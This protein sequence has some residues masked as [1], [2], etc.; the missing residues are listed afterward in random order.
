MSI[1]DLRLR[2]N[3]SYWRDTPLVFTT[4]KSLHERF[5]P[6]NTTRCVFIISSTS[7]A[8]E[9]L[10]VS[11]QICTNVNKRFTPYRLSNFEVMANSRIENRRRLNH[12]L[13]LLSKQRRAVLPAV[14]SEMDSSEVHEKSEIP[15]LNRK[16]SKVSNCTK[17]PSPNSSYIEQ[18][19]KI[20]ISS[21]KHYDSYPVEN[22]FVN[23]TENSLKRVTRLKPTEPSNSLYYS[24]PVL[25]RRID[26]FGGLAKIDD[27]IKAV[28]N[29][30]D[31]IGYYSVVEKSASSNLTDI[32][33]KVTGCTQNGGQSLTFPV[34]YQ[35][36]KNRRMQKADFSPY[37]YYSTKEFSKRWKRRAV[38]KEQLD[39]EIDRYMAEIKFKDPPTDDIDSFVQE[40]MTETEKFQ[41]QQDY[42][43]TLD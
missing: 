18:F 16:P 35:Y 37:S 40:Y 29:S 24:K 28:N 26:R 1:L 27:N 31:A 25:S 39:D 32:K 9:R 34:R 30:Y 11:S 14:C 4:R 20:N 21:A 7:S 42:M 23:A 15:I 12:E 43:D 3:W 6:Q 2:K 10:I 36:L 5:S 38:T 13:R 33:N 22:S 19:S 17:P 41:N 8:R